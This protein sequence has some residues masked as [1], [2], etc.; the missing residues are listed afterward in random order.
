MK[1]FAKVPTIKTKSMTKARQCK[2]I[3]NDKLEM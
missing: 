1:P 3:T 2:E